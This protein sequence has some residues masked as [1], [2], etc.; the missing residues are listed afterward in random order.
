MTGIGIAQKNY[1]NKVMIIGIDIGGTNIKGI[2][3]D[4]T[5]IRTKVQ[6]STKSKTNKKLLLDQI[7]KIIKIL[8]KKGKKIDGIG[9]GV[10]G[11]IDFKNQK[12][13]DPPNVTALRNLELGKLIEKKFKIKT[14]I[15]NDGHLMTLAE[16]ILG[17][18]KNKNNVVGIALGTGVGG[19]LVMNKK[20]IH[21]KNGTAG[22]IGHMTIDQHGR[23]CNCG[24]KGCIEAYLSEAGIRKTSYEFFNKRIKSFDLHQMAKKS[25]SRAIEA[26]NEVGKHLGLGLANV[27]DV[28]NPEIIVVGGGIARGAGELLINPAKKEMR[29]NILS[30]SAKKTPVVLAKLKEYAGAIGASLLFN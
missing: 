10:A 17:A 1:S 18:G 5:K 4:G 12:I 2:L 22:E 25:D 23:K 13:L 7:F 21:G 29:K 20:I 28:F 11:P 8:I 15:E 24:S 6:Y 19:G 16:T 9:I 3:L 14:I 26:W 27:V 30:E